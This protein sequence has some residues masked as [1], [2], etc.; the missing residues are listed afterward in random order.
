MRNAE[1]CNKMMDEYFSLDKGERVPLKLTLY[2]LS[3]KDCRN[4][5]RMLKS[6]EKISKAPLEI[7]VPIDD[8][9]IEA[10]MAKIDPMY[11]KSKNPISIRRWVVS[12]IVMIL[13]MLAFGLSPYHESS[14]A[15]TVSFYIFF[16]VAVTVYCSMFIGTNIDYF[17][18]MINTK[19]SDTDNRLFQKVFLS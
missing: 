19:K 2:F 1:L 3:C 10:V 14:R 12:G 7:P 13:F 11:N 9:S 6:A 5:V 15:I 18:K 8:S 4:Q 17:V 16:A